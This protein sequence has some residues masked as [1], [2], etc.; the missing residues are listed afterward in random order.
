MTVEVEGSVPL[1]NQVINRDDKIITE[2]WTRPPLLWPKNELM[3]GNC[4]HK[5]H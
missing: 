3:V 1:I 5:K 2:V 4:S